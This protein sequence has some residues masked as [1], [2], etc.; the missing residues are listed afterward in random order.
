MATKD[1]SQAAKDEPKTETR[2]TDDA[3]NDALIHVPR[4]PG[5]RDPVLA[6]P[7]IINFLLDEDVYK[8]PQWDRR[9]EEI[10]K[11]LNEADEARNRGD[12]GYDDP[13][14]VAALDDALIIVDVHKRYSKWKTEPTKWTS[15]M[16]S[17]QRTT[18]RLPN[19]PGQSLLQP[20]LERMRNKYK[21]FDS[22]RKVQTDG[23]F[24]VTSARGNRAVEYYQLAEELFFENCVN[25]ASYDE[26]I[27]NGFKSENEAYESYTRG[28]IKRIY[29]M[30]PARLADSIPT[31]FDDDHEGGSVRT[32]AEKLKNLTNY[33]HA[34]GWQR[35]AVQKCLNL[36]TNYENKVLNT[37]WRR[38]VLPY[39]QPNPI[40]K[41]IIYQIR[42]LPPEKVYTDLKEPYPWV[43]WYN[44]HQELVQI[45][46]GWQR[47][48]YNLENW[49]NFQRAALPTNFQ[50]PYINRSLSVY[51]D[52]WLRVAQYLRRLRRRLE[53]TFGM[54]PRPF[55]LAILRDIQAGIEWR[56]NSKANAT[57]W[58]PDDAETSRQARRDIMRR[59]GIDWTELDSSGNLSPTIL[60]LDESDAAWLRYLCEPSRTEAMCA[61]G[62]EPAD[63]ITILFDKRL[64]D[65]LNNPAVS[66]SSGISGINIFEPDANR[67]KEMKN[68]NRPN[69][70]EALAYINGHAGA[71][72]S[73]ANESYQ[74]TRFEAMKQLEKL[75]KLG[76]VQFTQSDEPDKMKE[77]RDTFIVRPKYEIHPE[78]RIYWRHRDP[79]SFYENQA[80]YKKAVVEHLE[81]KYGLSGRRVP[82]KKQEFEYILDHLGDST[83]PSKLAKITRGASQGPSE[84]GGEDLD[85]GLEEHEFFEYLEEDEKT[86]HNFLQKRIQPEIGWVQGSYREGGLEERRNAPSWSDLASWETLGELSYAR[87]DE[88]FRRE[89]PEE[90]RKKRRLPVPERTV[91]FFRN[92]A[93]RMGRT[94]AHAEEVER[95]L[96]YS[97]YDNVS[98]IPKTVQWKAI[99]TDSFRQAYEHWNL[100]ITNGLG[101]IEFLPPTLEDIVNRIDSDG[102]MR[103]KFANHGMADIIRE[104]IIKNCVENGNTMYPGRIEALEDSSG[105]YVNDGKFKQNK[106]LTGYKRP[107]LFKWAT[108]AQRRYQAPYTRRVY[109]TMMRW[110]LHLQNENLQEAIKQRED[111]VPRVDPSVPDQNH[112]ILMPRLPESSVPQVYTSTWYPWPSIPSSEDEGTKTTTSE[113]V[114]KPNTA[115]KT[116]ERTEDLN[117]TKTLQD[118]KHSSSTKAPIKTSIQKIPQDV[119]QQEPKVNPQAFLQVIHQ[120]LPQVVPQATPRLA[121]QSISKPFTPETLQRSIENPIVDQSQ[122]TIHTNNVNNMATTQQTT[123]KPPRNPR[124]VRQQLVP[125]TQPEEQFMPGPAIFPMAET[126]LQ[127]VVL[128]RKLEGVLYPE[129]PLGVWG[130]LR[131]V[132]KAL[133][134]VEA[135]RIPLLPPTK[136]SEIPRSTSRK[137]KIPADYIFPDNKK[138]KVGPAER[139]GPQT[140]GT[141][142]P[143]TDGRGNPQNL[144]TGPDVSTPIKPVEPVQPVQP[145]AGG[146]TQATTSAS[147]W[148]YSPLPALET[149]MLA[150]EKAKTG[151]IVYQPVPP[152]ATSA[153]L[154]VENPYADKA[155]LSAA[156][157]NGWAP[158][159]PTFGLDGALQ[160]ISY[161]MRLQDTTSSWLPATSALR[162]AFDNPGC[163]VTVGKVVDDQNHYG[164]TILQAEAALQHYVRRDGPNPYHVQLCCIIRQPSGRDY[165]THF[166][167]TPP[168]PGSDKPRQVWIYC[169]GANE[170]AP[171]FPIS[172]E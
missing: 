27:F 140:P 158:L 124:R 48:R 164:I 39:N 138:A 165:Y 144:Y 160:A 34:R 116:P 81:K 53:D 85:T 69:F 58:N 136:D 119:H 28:G 64:Q 151:R 172:K 96:Q 109:F 57:E 20:S 51:G 1:G 137:R 147:S 111:E 43:Y 15:H 32:D 154:G 143:A 59:P 68:K 129:P 159:G 37:P 79:K 145:P 86:S 13:F 104:G 46:A 38:V 92:L 162:A 19:F 105:Y 21:R 24:P 99:S 128:S 113:N 120:E 18:G 11:Y 78:N 23:V 171:V 49:E 3:V 63:N 9:L 66:H 114:T 52:Y 2:V 50:G 42:A 90:A 106:L 170:F 103:Y 83:L 100:T 91:Q 130:K 41:E 118:T 97:V 127:S 30:I 29:R 101:P 125:I 33:Y 75:R 121:V 95:R 47:R 93:Y 123:Q 94:I 132:Y 84:N 135:P 62:L 56:P 61:P 149:H 72:Q 73:H 67:W 70:N 169:T 112:G 82:I 155:A 35:A 102:T 16:I 89:V 12:L 115:T 17:V 146:Q 153:T 108:V 65:F 98:G 148:K 36:F 87:L 117:K 141:W 139:A 40:L 126:L 131:K 31:V 54:A 4:G 74:F 107:S 71:G 76:R 22:L 166:V 14:T 10:I 163:N 8:H 134:D 161:G 152:A 5:G 157:P 6:L 88:N 156:F 7:R 45:L 110:P 44:Q 60:L 25:P 142:T 77:D 168:F 55:L 26:L 122:T 133:T 150:E 167:P 80:L